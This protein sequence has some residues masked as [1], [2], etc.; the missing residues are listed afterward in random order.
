V[1]S[2]LRPLALTAGLIGGSTLLGRLLGYGFGRNTVVR[3]R[4][5]HLFTT[6]WIPG[7]KLRALDLGVARVQRCPVGRHWTLVRPVR[8]RNLTDADRAAAAAHR[9][10]RLP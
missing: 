6:I 4:A 8:Q 2:R 5:G 1:S 9:D 7:V 3:C 10:V